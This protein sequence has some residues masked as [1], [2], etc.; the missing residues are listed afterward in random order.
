MAAYNKTITKCLQCGCM[1]QSTQAR[2]FSFKQ[3]AVSLNSGSQQAM[4]SVNNQWKLLNQLK[5]YL[6]KTSPS[7]SSSRTKGSNE[8][9]AIFELSK[10]WI[11]LLEKYSPTSLLGYHF[12]RLTSDTQNNK[13]SNNRVKALEKPR[14]TRLSQNNIRR[15]SK[16]PQV[17]RV[18]ETDAVLPWQTNSTGSSKMGYLSATCHVLSS[19]AIAETLPA[20]LKRTEELVDLI[21]K[22]PAAR[23]YAVKEGAIK[24]LLRTREKYS[25]EALQQ[26]IREALAILGYVEQLPGRGIRILSID[27]GGIRGIAVIELLRKLEQISGRRISDMFDYI[28]GVS[29]G[30][31]LLSTVGIP[32]GRS[33]DEA[34]TLYKSLST[35]LFTQQKVKGYWNLAWSHAYYDTVKLESILRDYIGTMPMIQTNRQAKCPK[36]SIVSTIVNLDRPLPYLFRNY[37]IPHQRYSE[38]RGSHDHPLWKAVRAS[39][40]A[41]GYFEEFLLDGLV[42]QDGGVTVNNPTAVALHEASILWPGVPFQCI[43][44]C[45]TGRTL[46][47]VRSPGYVHDLTDENA[48]PDAKN[49]SLTTK[50]NRVLESATDTEGVHHVLE[51]LLPRGV[52][53]RFNP[54]LSEVIAMDET[55]GEKL[56]LLRRDTE[57]YIRKN[58]TR[59]KAATKTLL[60]EKSLT[61]KA[62][63]F[64]KHK[65]YLWNAHL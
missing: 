1:T 61:A 5:E 60:E 20:K 11:N 2:Q 26:V 57:D 37:S 40:A 6:S 25:D 42:H 18:V 39:S 62:M 21:S 24:L 31:I 23:V 63:D 32:N 29:T 38:Y 58:E 8:K 44:S 35:D 47:M 7:Q 56:S 52:Y 12:E 4:N 36:M 22:Y 41:P 16:V 27:G 65:G 34:L 64:V 13:N 15:V 53:Y 33:L 10:E 17:P 49:T 55:S 50:L 59:F 46:P 45:G 30:S 19:I 54:Y 28:C 43:V 48:V 3:L 9:H 51:D 14:L